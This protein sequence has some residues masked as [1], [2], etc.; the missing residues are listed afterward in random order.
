MARSR[1]Q[2][3]K[4]TKQLSGK[5][6]HATVVR[7]L[8]KADKL[9]FLESFAMFMGKAQLVEFGLKKILLRKYG[10]KE[11]EIESWPLGRV[12][13]ELK[14]LGLR[15]DFIALVEELKE[16][17]NYIAHEILADDAMM[18]K[19]AGAGTRRFARKS[20]ERGLYTVEE[21]IVVHDFLAGNKLL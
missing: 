18:Q 13:K 10:Y 3:M 19:L 11:E 17:R 20:L 14:K 21:V 16:H 12:V 8:R 1:E 15:R 9:N 4:K 5:Q 2:R 7:R 6:V